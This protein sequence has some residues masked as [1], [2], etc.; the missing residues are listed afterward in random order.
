MSSRWGVFMALGFGAC[1]ATTAFDDPVGF[2]TLDDGDGFDGDVPL[3]GL[4]PIPEDLLADFL[5]GVNLP[6]NNYGHDFGRAWGNFGVRSPDAQDRLNADFDALIGAGVARW[7]VFADGRA[8]D[9]S[10]PE[11]VFA[12]LD[13]ALDLAEA[14]GI[15]L[16]PVL[17][18]FK[19]FDEA[20]FDDGVQLFGRQ[21]LVTDPARRADLIETW[22]EPLAERYNDDRRIFAFDLINEPEW[23]ISDGLT[24]PIVGEPIT[25]AEM[26]DF[27]FDVARPLRQGR[28]LTVGCTSFDDLEAFWLDTPIDIF[29]LHHYAATEVPSAAD[30]MTDKPVLIGEFATANRD[31]GERL[32]T[33]EAL[34]YA[35]ALPWSLNGDD[36]ASSRQAVAAYFGNP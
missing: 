19:W 14:R 33:F 22:I 4:P 30:L 6:W 26:Q 12:D 27:V 20:N 35:G 36:N 7:F 2:A 25:L 29:Q 28:P 18:D 11:E 24:P 34:G 9:R 1:D 3:D 32:A 23:A 13:A 16:M 21:Y 15:A 17:F 31:L 8:L 5:V 10:T